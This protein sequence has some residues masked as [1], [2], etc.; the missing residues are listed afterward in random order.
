MSCVS[1]T[2]GPWALTGESV[3][4]VHICGFSLLPSRLVILNPYAL[5]EEGD[6]TN[7]LGGQEV[8][9][10]CGAMCERTGM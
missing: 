5:L 8:T 2:T 6:S 7:M 9:V 10:G 1:G 3:Q 4:E